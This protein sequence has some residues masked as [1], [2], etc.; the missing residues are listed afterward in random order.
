MTKNSAKVYFPGLNG[1]R[2]IAA[3]MVV[4]SHVELYGFN[5]NFHTLGIEALFT[6][7]DVAVIFFFVL[8]GFLITYLLFKEKDTMGT[9]SVKDFYMRRILRIWPLYYLLLILGFLILPNIAFMDTGNLSHMMHKYFW[10]QLILNIFLLPNLGR[11]CFTALPFNGMAWSIG[12]EEQFYF[13]WPILIKKSKKPLKVIIM[14]II[15]YIMCFFGAREVKHIFTNYAISSFTNYLPNII[16]YIQIDCMAIGAIGAYL[17]FYNKRLIQFV[18]S[19]LF[20]FITFVGIFIIIFFYNNKLFSNEIAS[21]FFCSLIIN[22]A[23]NKNTFLKLENK[24]FHYLGK[25]SYGIYMYHSIII[26]AMVNLFRKFH[27]GHNIIEI[28]GLH[29]L[30]LIITVGISAVSYRYFE[31]IFLKLKLKR[32]KVLSGDNV[33]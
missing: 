14:I 26:I 15:A 23:A 11:A 9:V 25:I 16:G 31:N 27:L 2:F 32:T 13:I 29:L 30:C 3:A 7:G 24:V 10:P 20:Q 17:L 19:P 18:F 1:L 4:V 22:V 8:S 21:F 6:I 5:F 28:L 12:V 33:N